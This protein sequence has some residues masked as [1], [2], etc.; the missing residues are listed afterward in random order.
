MS[1]TERLSGYVE[2][3]QQAVG[4]FVALTRELRQDEWDLPTDLPGWSVR[5]VVAHTAHL[6]AVLAGAPEETIEVEQAPHI[7]NL[8][9]AYTEQGVVARRGRDLAA[10]ADEI[11][12]S[13][14][15]RAAALRADPPSDGAAAP[16]RTPGGIPW[17]TQTL[18]SNRPVD[19]WMHEQDIRRATGRPGGYDSL[20]ADHT[21]RTLASAL[22]VVVG[23]RVAPPAGTTVV[24]AVPESGIRQAVTV[25]D[26]GRA[27]PAS[28]T[29]VPTVSITLSPEAFAV[30]AGG[31]RTPEQVEAQIEGDAELGRA[32]LSHL[33]VTP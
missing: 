24:L 19:V 10:L 33:A 17:D 14:A 23:K 16:P 28:D 8:T 32:V 2:A 4:R 20:A 11:E 22:P 6:E 7:R 5:D 18:L 30:L 26:D 3:W 12:S 25:G 1:D 13:A 21:L 15:T 29:E 27:H 9:G 31:R